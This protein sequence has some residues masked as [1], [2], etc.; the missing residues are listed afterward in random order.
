MSGYCFYI[1]LNIKGDFQICIRAPLSDFTIGSFSRSLADHGYCSFFMSV[2]TNFF[3]GWRCWSFYCN[4]ISFLVKLRIKSAPSGQIQINWIK[5]LVLNYSRFSSRFLLT[6]DYTIHFIYIIFYILYALHIIYLI[7][8][9]ASVI[10]MFVYKKVTSNDN[11]I[12]LSS[13]GTFLMNIV[14]V[15]EFFFKFRFNLG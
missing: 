13:I 3:C 10:G 11:I 6:I 12:G 14:N 15:V 9:N 2:H 4:T 8:F 1:N 5:R 7:K